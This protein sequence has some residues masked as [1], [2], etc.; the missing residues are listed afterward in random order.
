MVMILIDD[1][2]Y[3]DPGCYGGGEIA[4]PNIDAL[5]SEGVRFS[6]GYTAS[7]VCGP[8]RV[9]LLTGKQ[10]SQLGVQWNPDMKDVRLA[11]GQLLLPEALKAAGYHTV[12]VGKWNINQPVKQNLPATDFF[13]KS[14]DEMAWA[15]DYWP[16]E[17]GNYTG[18][19]D[20]NFGSSRENGIWGPLREGDEYLTDR[21]T[22]LA[23]EALV[24][25]REKQFFLFLAYNAP[26]SPLQGKLV[27][28]PLLTR[29]QGEAKKLYA[30]MVTA[31]DDGVGEVVQTLGELQLQNKT[32]VIFI[33]DNGP[34]LTNFHGMPD[35]WPRDEI[36]G[37]TGGLAGAKGTF[38]EGGIRVPFIFKWPGVWPRRIAYDAPITTLDLFPT[39][40]AIAKAPEVAEGITL[41]GADLSGSIFSMSAMATSSS[42]PPPRNLLWYA[43]SAGAVMR[44]DYKLIFE[45]YSLVRLYN[46]A[47]DPAESVDLAATEPDLAQQLWRVVEEWRLEIPPP[48]QPRERY[49][50]F[51]LVAWWDTPVEWSS[52]PGAGGPGKLPATKNLSGIQSLQVIPPF[53]S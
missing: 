45:N 43:G 42:P 40:L 15:A 13:E 5:A 26:H 4:T 11:P 14:Y 47:D 27:H 8:S 32:L 29:I 1:L 28:L 7:P 35:D 19:E 12:H 44:D 49:K 36:L 53:A 31:V 2:G 38:Y 24:E 34:A 25:S 16:D 51:A 39:L 46:V 10:P 9:G 48:I 17:H 21:L 30:S 52:W 50:D 23:R 20:D 3:G 22:R 18:V 33:S 41:H 6:R 37:S